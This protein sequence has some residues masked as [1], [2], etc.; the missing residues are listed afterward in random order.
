MV[1]YP[2]SLTNPSY[3]GQILVLSYPL[4]G[5]YGIS[6][7]YLYFYIKYYNYSSISEVIER[8]RVL[9]MTIIQK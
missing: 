8:T 1:G 2:E 3:L 6:D 7:P 5:N 4:I 9:Y